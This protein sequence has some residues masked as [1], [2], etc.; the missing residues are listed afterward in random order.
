MKMINTLGKATLIILMV[1]IF[2]LRH[3]MA[4]SN[5][6]AGLRFGEPTV[7]I[8]ATIP[9]A[10]APRLHAAAYVSDNF[11]LGGYFN[12]MFSLSEGPE[13]LKFYPGLGP[14]FWFGSDFDVVV[15][16][17]FG[18]E[19]SFDFPLSV[20]FDWRPG[21]VVT[22]GFDFRSNNIGLGARFRFGEGIRFQRE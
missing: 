11:G 3:G 12:W 1:S 16:G 4:Q 20:F 2:A 17:D 5:W 15:S 10:T 19:Y 14:E 6:E 21:F 22:D 18:A 7:A 13:G 9:L 8:D